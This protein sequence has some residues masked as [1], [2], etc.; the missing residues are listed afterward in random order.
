MVGSKVAALEDVGLNPTSA[1]FFLVY[2]FSEDKV[3]TNNF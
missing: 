1:D 2:Y 3:L